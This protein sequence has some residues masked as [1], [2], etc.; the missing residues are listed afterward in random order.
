M[1]FFSK[2][3]ALD[4]ILFASKVV[5]EDDDRF[6]CICAYGVILHIRNGIKYTV[7]SANGT[8]YGF[9]TTADINQST[10]VERLEFTL[11]KKTDVNL[12]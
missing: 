3:E 7:K 6:D 11:H 12:S 10:Q 1:K 5:Y 4:F 8:E 9:T 2:I